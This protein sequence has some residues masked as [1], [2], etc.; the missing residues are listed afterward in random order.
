MN[1]GQRLHTRFVPSGV[2]VVHRMLQERLQRPQ[3]NW[4]HMDAHAGCHR[5]HNHRVHLILITAFE[6]NRNLTDWRVFFACRATFLMAESPEISQEDRMMLG[7]FFA[8]A[9]IC[10]G[11]S[12]VFHTVICHSKWAC[13]TF[14]KFDYVGISVLILGSLIPWVYYSFYCETVAR[15]IY[16][17][18]ILVLGSASIFVSLWPK[19][20]T[21][22]YR[23]IFHHIV[24]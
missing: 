19:F 13:D 3:R 24:I 10:M 15:G 12:S 1:A 21:V 11:L 18:V 7:L 14:S 8:G 16:M 5:I 17:V 9:V 20:G 22:Q 23:S 4:Q 6:I 2:P